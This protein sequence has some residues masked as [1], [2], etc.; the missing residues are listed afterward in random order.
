MRKK[1]EFTTYVFGPG[2]SS[3]SVVLELGA[4]F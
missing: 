2:T 1:L 4:S 3:T